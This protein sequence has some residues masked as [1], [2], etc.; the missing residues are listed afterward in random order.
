M[1]DVVVGDVDIT[2][3]LLCTRGLEVITVLLSLVE[4]I[5]S[6]NSESLSILLE[7]A[8]ILSRSVSSASVASR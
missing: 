5:S 3:A 4:V 1:I 7:L 2:L 8:N 6:K